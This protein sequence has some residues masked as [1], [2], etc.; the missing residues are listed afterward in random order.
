MIFVRE[1][2]QQTRYVALNDLPNANRFVQTQRTSVG[3]FCLAWLGD[4]ATGRP[5][6]WYKNLANEKK[7]ER[8]RRGRMVIIAWRQTGGVPRAK[9]VFQLRCCPAGERVAGESDGIIDSPGDIV[10][11]RPSP[12][13]L[14][15]ARYPT[16]IV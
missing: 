4:S 14:G 11:F 12:S 9:N 6:G 15:L 8:S 1:R 3:S 16:S 13:S 5:L 2:D 7:R 10:H